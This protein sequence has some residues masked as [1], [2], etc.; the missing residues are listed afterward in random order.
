MEMETMIQMGLWVLAGG[1]LLMLIS[2]RR[3]RKAL[4]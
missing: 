4:R 1:I 3:K 2:R